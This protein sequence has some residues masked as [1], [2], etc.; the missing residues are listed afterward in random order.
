VER[1][2]SC[3]TRLESAWTAR[4]GSSPDGSADELEV[5]REIREGAEIRPGH[6]S[7]NVAEVAGSTGDGARTTVFDPLHLDLAA[8]GEVYS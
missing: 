1:W 2:S 8:S 6:L 3:T 4:G 5:D 7:A